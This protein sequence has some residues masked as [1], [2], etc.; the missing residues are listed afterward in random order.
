MSEEQESQ[1]VK[2]DTAE[3]KQKK[4][5]EKDTAAAETENEILDLAQRNWDKADW[6]I[7]QT[8]SGHEMKVK[9]SIEKRMFLEG[10]D[11]RVFGALI[12]MEKVTE[13]RNGEK[14]TVKKKFYPGYILII[15]KLYKDN[16]ELDDVV[17]NFIKETNG[18]TGFINDKPQPLSEREILDIKDM[19]QEDSE[20]ERPKIDYVVGEMVKI[21]DGSFQ[22]LEGKIEEID[23][24][25]GKLKLSVSIFGRSTPVDVGYWQGERED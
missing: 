9:E 16:Q 1:T 21:K 10:I 19:M 22:N 4:T 18:I 24:I 23:E 7:V 5:A 6:F 12:P 20:A 2:T 15:A 14:V 25:H 11:D 17:W 3:K 13:I 8:L